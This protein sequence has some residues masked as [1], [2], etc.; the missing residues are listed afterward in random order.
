MGNF[1][2]TFTEEQE[3]EILQHIFDNEETMGWVTDDVLKFA[4]KVAERNNIKHPFSS[5]KYKAGKDWLKGF[6]QGHSFLTLRA[7]ES[8]SAAKTRTFNKPT[9]DKFFSILK[10]VQD[11][12]AYPA[13]RIF[14]VDETSL[15]TVPIKNTNILAKRGRK[16]VARITSAERGKSTAVIC[17]SSGGNFIPPM[18]IFRR[19]RMQM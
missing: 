7:P 8:T 14:Y 6:R 1:I 19:L 12:H 3:E 16:Q 18:L 4:Y 13:Y 5:T 10:N 2:K 17:G 11:K 15:N 9:A